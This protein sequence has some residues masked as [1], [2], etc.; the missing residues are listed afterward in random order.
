MS[1]KIFQA[2]KTQWH[3]S[4]Y[5]FSSPFYRHVPLSS[6]SISNNQQKINQDITLEKIHIHILI[7][8]KAICMLCP[9]S[10][11][12]VKSIM[13]EYFC[14]HFP[15]STIFLIRISESFKCIKPKVHF[16]LTEMAYCRSAKSRIILL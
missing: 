2:N 3:I 8:N 10:G 11:C 16:S 5:P 7:I 15:I 14:P 6:V 4:K 13:K 12:P 9:V 1:N